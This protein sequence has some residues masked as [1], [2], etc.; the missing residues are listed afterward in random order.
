MSLML[1]TD[2]EI[3]AVARDGAKLQVMGLDS[4][5]VNLPMPGYYALG[6]SDPTDCNLLLPKGDV[7]PDGGATEFRVQ[8][9][10]SVREMVSNIGMNLKAIHGLL[11]E[12]S[13]SEISLEPHY[14][15][16][17]RY[18]ALLPVE[19]GD[20]CSLQVLGCAPDYSVYAL[21]IPERPDPRHY[22]WRT[23][24][25]HIHIEVGDAIASDQ[26][27]T[28]WLVAAL[29]LTI[30]AASTMLTPDERSYR[31]KELYG[32]AGMVRV[33]DG[34]IE[35]R[36]LPAQALI[37]TPAVCELMFETAQRVALYMKSI[38]ESLPQPEAIA[39]FGKIVGG[40]G[41]LVSTIVP[42]IN[43]HNGDACRDLQ[44]QFLQRLTNDAII[45]ETVNELRA[46][47]LPADYA[48]HDWEL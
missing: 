20:A 24:G 33:K 27:A 7:G 8:P 18:I 13:G 35:Y 28:A 22:T 4:S 45:A 32:W 5:L 29:D 41:E 34:R 46:M 15:M 2:P 25:G 38:Y 21:D 39:A 40:Y 12:R 26:A 14:F 23:L 48:L 17:P 6:I 42:A 43:T 31:R 3:V 36:T 44:A 19:Y 9:T 1:G 37:Q 47:K 10:A 30:G 16:D 11:Q